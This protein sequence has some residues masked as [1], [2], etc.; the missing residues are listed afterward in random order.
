MQL[1]VVVGV[2]VD[3]VFV[4]RS[5]EQLR[6]GVQPALGV[7]H[8]GWA[9]VQAAEVAVSV[10]ERQPH[11]ERL[12][13]ADERV[14]DG[15]VTVG[16]QLAHDLADDAGRLHVAAVGAQ[17]HVVHLEQ[18]PAVHRL[19]A[20]A[21]VRQRAAVDDRVGVLEKAA[22]HLV[23]DVDVDDRLADWL[24]RGLLAGAAGLA[25]HAVRVLQSVMECWWDAGASSLSRRGVSGGADPPGQRGIGADG[26]V[27]GR[28]HNGA[29]G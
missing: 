18:D 8:G 13:H 25:G 29:H 17:A 11:R 3:D 19:Q 28:C 10:D 24:G 6:R 5:G 1:A 21:G 27:G 4:D 14:V 7:A 12:R 23:G 20:V 22:L 2:E 9:G 15:A 26:G 16:V